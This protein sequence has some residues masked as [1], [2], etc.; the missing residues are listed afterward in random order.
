MSAEKLD[1]TPRDADVKR[2]NSMLKKSDSDSNSGEFAEMKEV[3]KRR[4]SFKETV[5]KRIQL[6]FENVVISTVQQRRTFF[7]RNEIIPESRGIINSVSGTILPGQF[8]AILGSS[9]NIF[10]I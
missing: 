4:S 7:N 6:T 3:V 2:R 5:K 9:G 8:V 1:E 10:T